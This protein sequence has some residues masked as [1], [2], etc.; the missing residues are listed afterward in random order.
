MISNNYNALVQNNQLM[1]QNAKNIAEISTQKNSDISLVKEMADQIAIKN[2]N[3]L[4]I[5]TI[6]TQD[7]MLGTLLD[8]KA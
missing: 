1:N 6:K 5:E 4:N 3:D 8:M 2:I 7:S